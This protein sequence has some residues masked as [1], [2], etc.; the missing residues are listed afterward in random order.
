[1]TVPPKR[2]LLL[3]VAATVASFAAGVWTLGFVAA[4]LFPDTPFYVQ[5]GTT[6]VGIISPAGFGF[7]ALYIA[8]IL[9]A[10]GLLSNRWWSQPLLPFV[11]VLVATPRLTAGGFAV[12][13]EAVLALTTATIAG[14]YVYAWRSPRAYY[15]SVAE[16]ELLDRR[17]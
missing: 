9:L 10:V 7:L 12:M 3:T 14:L 16:A 1:M 4:L 8:T 17:P 11:F 6:V 13:Q 5:A 15:K 2:P